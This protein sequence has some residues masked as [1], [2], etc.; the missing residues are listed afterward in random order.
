MKVTN[1]LIITIF[2]SIDGYGASEMEKLIGCFFHLN[3]SA[4]AVLLEKFK[5]L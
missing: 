3:C 2:F 4:Q 1:T 5:L